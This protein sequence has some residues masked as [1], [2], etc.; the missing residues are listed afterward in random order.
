M[1]FQGHPQK[2]GVNSVMNKISIKSVNHA[3][4][5]NHLCSAPPVESVHN[6][7]KV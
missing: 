2:K 3:S 6:V 7:V 4:F 1:F 5:G